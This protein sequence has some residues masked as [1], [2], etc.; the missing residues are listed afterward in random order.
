MNIPIY[1]Y[2]HRKHQWV[3]GSKIIGWFSK[4]NK[5]VWVQHSNNYKEIFPIEKTYAVNE[6]NTRRIFRYTMAQREI[7]K[8]FLQI[9]NVERDMYEIVTSMTQPKIRGYNDKKEEE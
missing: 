8:L 2:S 6:E 1:I 4:K 7:N 9:K 3:E 5:E